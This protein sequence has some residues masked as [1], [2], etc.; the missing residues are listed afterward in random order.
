LADHQHAVSGHVVPARRTPPPGRPRN[1]RYW[2][3]A[4]RS[5]WPR[6]TSRVRGS[7]WSCALGGTA[8]GSSSSLRAKN[9][10]G[11]IINGGYRSATRPPPPQQEVA[12]GAVR[13]GGHTARA[14]LCS[15]G[16]RQGGR[17]RAT[18]ARRA[19]VCDNGRAG[20]QRRKQGG[21]DRMG[22]VG[23]TQK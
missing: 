19:R 9:A 2:W 16:W 18:V 14:H 4:P 15:G 21:A 8:S 17:R 12:V 1:A 22:L 10:Y 6:C 20:A 5:L 7:T 13:P 3:S 11:C 23:S